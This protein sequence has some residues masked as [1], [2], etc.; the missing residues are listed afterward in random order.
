MPTAGSVPRPIPTRPGR[1]RFVRADPEEAA[2]RLA[3]I[4][5]EEQ[6]DVLLTYDANG[7]YGHRDHVKVHEV[8]ARAAEIAGTPGCCR[9]PCR[10]T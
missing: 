1:V 7:G 5:R 4:L 8:G 2:E 10:A 6:A 3:A 9:P